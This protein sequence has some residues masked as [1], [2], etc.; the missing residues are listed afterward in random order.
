MAGKNISEDL[1]VAANQ[2]VKEREYW[3]KT[4][5]GESG[6]SYFPYDDVDKA[7]KRDT[8]V[9][10]E[11]RE[12]QLDGSVF[13]RIME[14]SRG[15]YHTVHMILLAAL[16][17][18]VNKY[19]GRKDIVLVTPI[20]KQDIDTALLINT[21]L[22]LRNRFEENTTFKELLI[23]VREKLLE[24]VEHY[25][26]P[27]EVLL[28]NLGI[29]HAEEGGRLSDIA[30]WL[31]NI[32][33]R[34]YLENFDTNMNFSFSDTDG[35]M[36]GTIKYNASLYN[37][38]TVDQL[39]DH[40]ENL[41]RKCLFKPDLKVEEIDI[42]SE[43]ERRK[44]LFDF[45]DTGAEF[46]QEKN[47]HLLFEEQVARTPDGT[48]LVFEDALLTY[49]ELNSRA[50]R[51]AR[52][53]RRKGVNPGTI[54]GL[55]MNRSIHM[56]VGLIGILKAGGAYMP[57]DAGYP[58]KRK[59]AML[60]DSNTHILLTDK[61]VMESLPYTTF[62]DIFRSPN[63]PVVTA[64]R[65]PIK[66]LN[67]LPRLN[68]TLIN[69]EEYHKH[70]G[71]GMVGNSI[72]FQGTRGCPFLCAYC[73]RIWPKTHVVRSAEDIFEEIKMYYDIGIRR[74]VFVDDVFNLDV[75]N[76]TRFFQLIVKNG[77]KVHFHN[78]NGLRGDIL[79]KEYIDLMIEAGTV[80]ISV[81]LETASPR[82]QKLIGKNLNIGK[83]CENLNYILEKYP[84]VTI[85]LQ[86]MHGFPTETEE[87]A[88]MT[89]NMIK[90]FK[91][92]DIPYVHLLKIYPNTD[93]AELAMKNGISRE[94]IER[95]AD[96]AYHIY[97]ETIPFSKNFTTR[98][99]SILTSEY[100]L[101][102][103]RLL[104]VIPRQMKI[105][106]ESE[107]V[108][109][110]DS[111]LPAKINTLSDVLELGGISED[112][113]ESTEFLDDD[114]GVVPDFNTKVK[115]YFP[116][117]KPK[118]DAL[119]VLLLD[120][121]MTFS[122]E[123][124]S[125]YDIADT[126][127]GLMSI[128][129]YL[130]HTLGD[131]VD[132]KI[133]KSRLDFDNYSQLKVLL[134]E[135][136]PDVIGLRTLTYFRNSFHKVVEMI[137][138]WGWEVPIIAGGPY[139]TGDYPYLLKDAHID[140]VVLGEG[141]V[142][143]TEIIRAVMKHGRKL[144]GDEVLEN[145]NGIAFM[146]REDK[147]ALRR[148]NREIIM[149]DQMG[150]AMMKYSPK[151]LPQCN[152][153]RDPAYVLYTSGTSGRPKGVMLEHKNLTNLMHFHRY[154]MDVDFSSRVFQFTT[155]CFDVSFQEIFSTLSSG[156][157]L[158]LIRD[159]KRM[160]MIELLQVIEKNRVNIV[161]FP[162]SYLRIL[163]DE[164][165]YNEMF[166]ASVTHIITAGEQLVV[167][168]RIR[169][170]LKKNG[171]TL[172]NHYGPSET[173][174]VTTLAMTP[175]EDIPA[176]PPIGTPIANTRIYILGDGN[177]LQPVGV[178]GE[179]Y[180][181][182]DNVGRGYLNNPEITADRFVDD[183]ITPGA[184]CYKT[185]DLA[186]WLP[187]GN[188]EFLGRKDLQVKVR[189]FRI[190]LGEIENRLLQHKEIKEAVVLAR[191][192][193]RGETFLCA[194]YVSSVEIEPSGL[195]DFLAEVLP[196]YMIPGYLSKLEQ[197]PLKTNGKVDRQYLLQYIV[198]AEKKEYT[199]PR[200]E[201]DV[202][203]T[204]IW[205]E[206]L[207][208][209]KTEIGI[210]TDFF[211]LGGHSLKATILVS[212]MHKAF[213][214][215]L[216]LAEVF[217]TPTIR[218][219]SKFISEASE[220]EFIALE[221]VGEKDVY[222]LS[223]AQYRLYILWQLDSKNLAY[224][225]PQVIN[226]EGVPDRE[227][228][229]ATLGKL[230]KRHGSLRTSFEMGESQPVQ[231]VHK[232]IPFDPDYYE[233]GEGRAAAIVEE[234]VRPFDLHQPPLF[235][236]GVVKMPEN[237]YLV[238]VDI[239][240]IISDG[241]SQEILARD[242]AALYE[243]RQLPGLRLQYVDFAEW[244]NMPA[245]REA[246]EQQEKYWL[247]QFAEDI[248]VLQLPV[249]FPGGES[250]G[251]SGRTEYFYIGESDTRALR[252]LAAEEGVTIYML[253]MAIFN[254]LLARLSG[255][256]DI[257]V[258]T[259]VAGRRHTDLENII[260]MF[261]NTLAMRRYPTAGKSFSGFLKEVKESTLQDFENQDYPY[262]S[263]VEKV[264][265]GRDA[266]RNSLFNVM[267]TLQNQMEISDDQVKD[268]DNRE[269]GIS[270]ENKS[271]KFDI[272]FT[273]VERKERFACSFEYSTNLFKKDTILRYIRNLNEIVTGIINNKHVN[274]M[275][276]TISYDLQE[277]KQ[278]ALIEDFGF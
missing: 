218:G 114:F 113:L 227:R 47:I 259:V 100:F 233:A 71:Q 236:V 77:L 152:S 130:L 267:F 20:Y 120:L 186:R 165:I 80:N 263:L 39:Q 16:N 105:L 172:H 59:L 32:H 133:A 149:L 73:H 84:H 137:R 241:V 27:V 90:Q 30:V 92:I 134:E 21:V 12:F 182:G 83:M 26:Y 162:A 121:S 176:L 232:H 270:Y 164:E 53:L 197:I 141:E 274:L 23:Q 216:R 4:L 228:L 226:F 264:I 271:A 159:E 192:D 70:I 247:E 110:Y 179:L 138:H 10:F 34:E 123:S 101:S 202:K 187:N 55:M 106:K 205:S 190:E 215:K 99:Q 89:L 173:H 239:H 268:G 67:S 151:E 183:P 243:G 217:N 242:F 155:I 214:V 231:R 42:L 75:K 156:G 212:K 14:L 122:D 125:I 25:S 8:G 41:L 146:G 72:T 148:A 29:S 150:D 74:F 140:I 188:I 224:N 50:N 111:Y 57:I 262:E 104:A 35:R 124:L 103:E 175:G 166:P 126:P 265:R 256:E 3:R 249:D 13:S 163:L 51:L 93:M 277:I 18:L 211:E 234:F 95:A 22:L 208:M 177:R 81:A 87:E 276:T 115:T 223:S 203:L 86:T 28:D 132:G 147:E 181:S 221:A 61:N 15:N 278:A 199:A 195:I 145:I 36:M 58:V 5:S 191:E 85:E 185:G 68:R 255:Q 119:K 222:S 273:A 248:P 96:V 54:V 98:Y 11:T 209:D 135:F 225:L 251:F 219:F 250:R 66:D 91:W 40:M 76:S 253:M 102:K 154:G 43:V 260:G 201:M 1:L 275:D 33:E 204:G 206:V 257:V 48:A 180:I 198:K 131:S 244:R 161:F 37:K 7:G 108:Q 52:Y 88:M 235:R 168:D 200:N 116:V 196:D 38:G 143:F 240:H 127:L 169:R 266:D 153:N 167:T 64:P 139:A 49:G 238:L 210:D 9:F 171:V 60:N 261:V 65:S 207:G 174:V 258:G 97:S 79:T 272:T 129:T 160:D 237:R 144:P 229:D 109:K 63:V 46:P 178:A 213:N 94:S 44:L 62:Q 128:M 184:R 220:D 158:C 157:E 107:F 170:Y 136:K 193:D 254:V 6:N 269:S 69:Y 24:A 82:L 252:N 194:F 118:E 230:I 117:L 19:T 45:N 189:G 142:T 56:I 17:V 31:D 2:K 112:Q 246:I 78:P 245:R